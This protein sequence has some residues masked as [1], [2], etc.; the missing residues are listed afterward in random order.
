MLRHLGLFGKAIE[1][2]EKM[3]DALKDGSNVLNRIEFLPVLT[4]ILLRSESSLKN[5]VDHTLELI[6]D[7]SFGVSIKSRQ[8]YLERLIKFCV[9]CLCEETEQV[10]DD[11]L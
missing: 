9:D 10:S 1:L 4:Q 2:I 6:Q 11:F 3:I 8:P 5:R 7:V